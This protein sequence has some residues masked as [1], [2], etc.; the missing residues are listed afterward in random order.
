MLPVPKEA[1]PTGTA[2]VRFVPGTNPKVMEERVRAAG[3]I[4]V[5]FLPSIDA[6]LVTAP[7]E[8]RERLDAVITKL[9]IPGLVLS[10]VR[11]PFFQPHQ[12]TL[13]NDLLATAD[14]VAYRDVQLSAAAS[15]LAAA[16]AMRTVGVAII[17]SGLDATFGSSSEFASVRYYDLCTAQGQA[18]TPTANPT[19]PWTHG[20]LVTGIVAG[21]NNGAGNNGVARI[22]MPAL[23][24]VSVFGTQCDANGLDGIHII[25]AME[26]IVG[27]NLGGFPIVL[28]PFGLGSDDAQAKQALIDFFDPFFRSERG[29]YTL[30]VASAGNN[31][32]RSTCNGFLQFPAGMACRVP[33]AVSV[34][35]HQPLS[36]VFTS[37]S[38]F[39]SAP[40]ISAP[41]EAVHTA[42]GPAQYGPAGGTSAAAAMVAGGAALLL[43][44]RPQPASQAR[45][46]IRSTALLLSDTHGPRGG[47]DVNAL[48]TTP[49]APALRRSTQGGS[50]G[51]GAS[52][53][54]ATFSS[55]GLAGFDLDYVSDD[56]HV[57]NVFAGYWPQTGGAFI[58]AN[59]GD[60]NGDDDYRWTVDAQ[61]LPPG[62]TFHEASGTERFAITRVVMP[63]GTVGV[64]ILTG[65]EL[66]M[67]SSDR[68]LKH[69]KVHVYR[70]AY[71]QVELEVA[72]EDKD[73]YEE[74]SYRVGYAMVPADRVVGHGVT[75]GARRGSDTQPLGLDSHHGTT[76]LQGFSLIFAGTDHHIDQIGVRVANSATV[77]YNDK[78]DDEFSWTVWWGTIE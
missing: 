2:L 40:T 10:I 57:K 60:R 1:K 42:T 48:I 3:G 55:P 36:R 45:D 54:R 30:W 21:A 53:A 56:H 26:L 77:S 22:A 28:M 68:H 33:N 46:T 59:L 70:D 75:S 32:T 43:S 18:G 15:H 49:D 7:G 44:A 19:S 64:P 50:S 73:D 66:H 23:I 12:V 25:E 34:A 78:N 16:T 51:G 13:D 67:S 38:N 4:P 63:Q 39:G 29:Q 47:L 61:E 24:P 62:T 76:A 17:D 11:V 8:G 9:A 20:T 41:G 72:F 65:F 5:K 52:A 37:I 71:D 6:V 69:I 35:G 27:G 58:N 31:A 74:F 14:S